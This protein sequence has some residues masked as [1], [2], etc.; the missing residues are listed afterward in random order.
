MMPVNLLDYSLSALQVWLAEL[1]EPSFRAAQIIQWIHQQGEVD[2]QRMTN[3]SKSL[4][5]RLAEVAVVQVPTVVREQRAT[6]G[7][8]KWLLKL[9]CG[10]CIETVFI[11]ERGRGTLCVSSQ[12]GCGLTCSFCATAKQGFNRN[13]TTGEIIGQVWLAVRLLSETGGAHDQRVTNVVMMGMGEPLLN[14][15]NVV[16]A[17][18]VNDW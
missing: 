4:R 2:F 7:T 16:A 1:G 18:D 11:P 5:Q 15:E 6:D 17:N 14:L 9:S 13:L 10:N 3:L 8:C 12:I